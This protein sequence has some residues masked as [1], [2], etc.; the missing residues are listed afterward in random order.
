MDLA[1]ID[2]P[3]VAGTFDICGGLLPGRLSE[4]TDVDALAL[5]PYLWS[6]MLKPCHRISAKDEEKLQEAMV[7]VGM[8]AI[9]P[10]DELLT[11]LRGKPIDGGFFAV[12]KP[13]KPGTPVRQ[14]LIFD[15]RPQN[16][17]ERRLAWIRLPH[18]CL[19]RKASSRRHTF[20]EVLGRIYPTIILPLPMRSSRGG[21]TQQDVLSLL[22]WRADW[23][24]S[25]IWV[26]GL[27]RRS[28]DI[29]LLCALLEWATK[30]LQTLPR[31]FTR[32]FWMGLV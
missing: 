20:F 26:L 27:F 14:R 11:D 28:A 24:K 12:A 32:M 21:G 6:E 5:E 15:R 16:C 9:C 25:T 29:G 17:T 3:E 19:F 18:A 31:R 23:P 13:P 2:L 10:E 7:R 1:A 22:G 8:G 4:Y 30:T